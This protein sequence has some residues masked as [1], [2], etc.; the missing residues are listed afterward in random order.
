[1]SLLCCIVKT[2]TWIKIINKCDLMQK[3]TTS[4]LLQAS[5]QLLFEYWIILWIIFCQNY[6]HVK[7]MAASIAEDRSPKVIK[8]GYIKKKGMKMSHDRH[9]ECLFLKENYILQ[10]HVLGI[11]L[12]YSFLLRKKL[13]FVVVV[14]FKV[15]SRRKMIHSKN[16][17]QPA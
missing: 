16:K 4:F 14:V 7:K 10:K 6:V 8:Q 13:V 17:K 12:Y 15:N 9:R 5:I 11:I 1:M 2:W 3:Y